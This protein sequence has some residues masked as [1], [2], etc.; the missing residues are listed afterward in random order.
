MPGGF[1][2]SGALEAIERWVTDPTD[3][4]RVLWHNPIRLFGF[5]G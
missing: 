4:D 3:R 2:Y 1:R 5:D